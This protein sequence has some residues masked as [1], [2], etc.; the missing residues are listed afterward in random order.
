MA[1]KIK[2]LPR[3]LETRLYLEGEAELDQAN[4]EVD[5]LLVGLTRWCATQFGEAFV[6]WLHVKAVRAFVE[7]ILRYGLPQDFATVLL[8]PSP[9]DEV[10]TEQ[11]LIKAVGAVASDGFIPADDEEEDAEKYTPC[12][13]Q[14]FAI[15]S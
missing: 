7:S 5:Q 14:K 3:E 10:K 8:T 2:A 12:V 4:L 9:R 13:L 11:A 6:A 1:L 15:S